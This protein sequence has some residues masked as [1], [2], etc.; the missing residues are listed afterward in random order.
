MGSKR[1]PKLTPGI[2]DP[3]LNSKVLC[4]GLYPSKFRRTATSA[5]KKAVYAAYGIPRLKR[6]L[7]RLDDIVPLELGGV[8]AIGN[9]W[10]Q[11]ILESFAKDKKENELK[12]LVCNGKMTLAEAQNYFLENW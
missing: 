3:N 12:K 6:I 1:D 7:Y 11:P 8:N 4:A 9:L 2:I 10:P 5:E